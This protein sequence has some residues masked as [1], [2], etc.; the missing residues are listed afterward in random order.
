M[1]TTTADYANQ[2]NTDT[3]DGVAG[4]SWEVSC[5]SSGVGETKRVRQTNNVKTIIA[6]VHATPPSIP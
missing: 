2:D 1:L 6:T 3:R 5:K 4:F